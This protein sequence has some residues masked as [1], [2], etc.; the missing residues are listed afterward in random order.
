MLPEWF[1]RLRFLFIGK[2]RREVDDEIQ[3]HVERQVEANLAAGMTLDEARREAAVGFGGRERTRSNAA[4]S[5]LP[6]R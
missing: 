4:N 3:F 2:S 1:C 6:F 5:G